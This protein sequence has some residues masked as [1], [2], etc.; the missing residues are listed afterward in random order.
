MTN[1]GSTRHFDSKPVSPKKV[2]TIDVD[3]D[4]PN[5]MILKLAL[6][7][8]ERNITLNELCIEILEE[9]LNH[10]DCTHEEVEPDLDGHYCVDCGE[11]VEIE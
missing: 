1:P 5:D 6:I 11:R 4:L 7:A 8:H 10:N 2:L 9:K 3:I